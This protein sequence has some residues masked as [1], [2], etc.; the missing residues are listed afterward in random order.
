MHDGHQYSSALKAL[1]QQCSC[2]H[3]SLV[4]SSKGVRGTGKFTGTPLPVG[5]VR[6]GNA[7]SPKWPDVEVQENR[8]ALEM[9]LPIF[10]IAPFP[11]SDRLI[12]EKTKHLYS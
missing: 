7:Q 10:L 1:L 3:L 12:G 8:R 6:D 9:E 2:V 5:T 4:V 11:K